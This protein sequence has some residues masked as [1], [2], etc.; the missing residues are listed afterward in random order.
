MNPTPQPFAA[1]IG[2]DWADQQHALCMWIAD[3][4]QTETLTLT[5]RPEAI[6][7]FIAS[8]R[9][10]FGGRPVALA[11]EQS[12]GSLIH[13][14]MHQEFLVLYPLP[15]TMLAAFRKAFAPSGRKNDPTDAALALEILRQHRDRLRPWNPDDVAT[16]TLALLCEQRR[17]LVNQRTALLQQLIA[18]LKNHFPQALDWCGDDLTSPMACD[19]LVKWPTLAAVQN[20]KPHVVRAF[21]YGH[22]SRNAALIAER[23]QQIRSARALCPDEAIVA[24]SALLTQALARQLRLL[25][26]L[27]A[28]HER[29]IAEAFAAHPDADIF[30]SLPGAGPVFAPRLLAAFGSDRT[31]WPD[32]LSLQQYSGIAPVRAASGQ[33]GQV[34][35]R[36]ACPKYQRQTFH[37]FAAQSLLNCGWARACYDALRARGKGHHAAVRAV[38]FKWIRL[39]MRLWKDRRPYDEALHQHTLAR[40]R[41]P[42]AM[43]V[44][45]GLAA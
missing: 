41:S 24:T 13:A 6:A 17:K 20:A 8:L 25:G 16:R 39:L 19:F 40:R 4:D 26:Q 3:T 32:A 38:A 7:E 10:R 37:E 30:K 42:Y 34:S 1:L 11:L 45:P 43:A 9:T 15:S 44:L 22:R 28:E 35:M 23:L 27:I 14:L 5:H 33:R 2:V 29:R 31:R 36:R 18:A 12:R 21:Y